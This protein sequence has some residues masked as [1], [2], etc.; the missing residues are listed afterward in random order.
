MG[1][2]VAERPR[3]DERAYVAEEVVARDAAREDRVRV[4]ELPADAVLVRGAATVE[5]V[6]D[7][8]LVLVVAVAA[9]GQVVVARLAVRVGAVDE[10]VAVVVLPVGARGHAELGLRILPRV[11]VEAV[12]RVLAV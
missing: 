9:L 10:P 7:A 2:A 12:R 11:A 3:R 4:A 6:D 5:V 8:V 1:V